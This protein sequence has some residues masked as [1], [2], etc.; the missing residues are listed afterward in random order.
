MSL[1]S[2]A[3]ILAV[4]AALVAVPR[5]TRKAASLVFLLAILASLTAVGY[6]G[7]RIE[8]P[9]QDGGGPLAL[10]V[11]ADLPE[12]DD[13]HYPLATW[14]AAHFTYVQT[15]DLGETEC[16]DCH[17]DPD[18]FCNQC[19]D[20]VG[21]Q[22]IAPPPS[23]SMSVAEEGEKTP[24]EPT[25]GAEEE[26][27]QVPSYSGDIQPLLDEKCA[28]CHIRRKRGGFRAASYADVFQGGLNGPAIVPGDA[29]GSLLFQTLR[30]PVEDKDIRQM[31]PRKPLTE[32]E[33]DLIARWIE[34]GAPDN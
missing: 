21:V 33:I 18:T 9:A 26:T 22:L 20:Y 32:A 2:F 23:A 1:L 12:P 14:R 34:A 24:L 28:A 17:D 29:E 27:A 8:K 4:V 5:R 31:P 13:Y 19:H 15:S 16:L 11:P 6:A 7:A 25:A 10:V 30:G 3:L